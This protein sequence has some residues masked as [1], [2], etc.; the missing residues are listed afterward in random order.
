M[1]TVQFMHWKQAEK[2][3]AEV[4]LY[5]TG[6]WILLEN[7]GY[8]LILTERVSKWD[9]TSKYYVPTGCPQK[10]L[11]FRIFD[12][13]SILDLICLWCTFMDDQAIGLKRSY[14]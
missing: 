10:I 9:I 1:Y 7:T 8:S 3:E 2:S 12:N 11:G 14:E 4:M 5:W 6:I 13:Y